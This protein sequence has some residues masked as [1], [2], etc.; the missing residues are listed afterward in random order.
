[1]SNAHST[2]LAEM[3]TSAESTSVKLLRLVGGEN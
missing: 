2:M 1:M 3:L